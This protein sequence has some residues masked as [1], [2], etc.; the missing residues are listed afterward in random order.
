MAKWLS[1]LCTSTMKAVRHYNNCMT[2][3]TVAVL[4]KLNTVDVYR[5]PCRTEQ[6]LLTALFN[7]DDCIV[8]K[9][10]GWQLKNNLEWLSEAELS[11]ELGLAVTVFD[12][13]TSTNTIAK[14]SAP[15][16]L[17]TSEFQY[18]GRGQQGTTW[19]SAPANSITLSL[20]LPCPLATQ[21]LSLAIGAMICK[22]LGDNGS[23]NGSLTLKWPND[24]LNTQHRKVAGMLLEKTDDKIIVGVGINMTMNAKMQKKIAQL[25]GCAAGLNDNRANKLSRHSVVVAV[26]KSVIAVVMNY[27]NG[28]TPYLDIVNQCHQYQPGDAITDG[29]GAGQAQQFLAID[30]QGAFC[31]QDADG[32][33][34]KHHCRVG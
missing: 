4:K 17:V 12:E 26:A 31:V 2:T 27:H 5:P 7:A 28:L 32:N 30:P 3:G 14:Q 15:P 23:D 21:G 33:I 34:K 1:G 8:K 24:L 13:L 16:A 10:D 6:N 9:G 11:A 25:G 20:V 19:L 29:G 18:Q 22:N